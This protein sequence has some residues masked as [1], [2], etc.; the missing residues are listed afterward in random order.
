MSLGKS[1][2]YRLKR[3]P[4]AV[5][6]KFTTTNTIIPIKPIGIRNISHPKRNIKNQFPPISE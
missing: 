4:S 3:D 1:K 6:I 2:N 5:K